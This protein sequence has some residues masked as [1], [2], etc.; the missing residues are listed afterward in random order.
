MK[1][2]IHIVVEG[3]LVQAVYA[4]GVEVDVRLHDLDTEDANE[5]METAAII[6]QLPEFAKKVY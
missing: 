3:G 4:E 1:K 2:T 6:A 5:F